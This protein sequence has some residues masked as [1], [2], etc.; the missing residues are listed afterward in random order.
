MVNQKPESECY[1]GTGPTLNS[2]C[3][4]GNTMPSSAGSVLLEAGCHRSC[5]GNHTAFIRDGWGGMT[6]GEGQQLEPRLCMNTYSSRR[7][8]PACFLQGKKNW[9]KEFSSDKCHKNTYAGI[10]KAWNIC[11]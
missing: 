3:E 6:G 1:S 4:A 8:V 9:L 7:K 11:S 5:W 2:P 10:C